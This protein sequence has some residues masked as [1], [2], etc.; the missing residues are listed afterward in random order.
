M[1][2]FEVNKVLGAVL[3]TLLVVDVLHLTADAVFAPVNPK[4]PG[5]VIAAPG[6]PATGPE[7]AASAPEEP[8]AQLLASASVERGHEATRVCEA[9]H[10][11]NKGG[12]NRVGPNLWGVV[13]RPRASEPGFNYS[14]AMKSEGGEWTFEELNKFLTNPRRDIPGTAMTFAGIDRARQRA[15]VIA[16][17]RTLSDN[18]V[19]LPSTK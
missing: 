14:T 10:T 16:Y 3:G 18:P 12:S 13:D 7:P 17:L 1:D 15:D 11:F 5:Y 8:I 9:C 19:P 6:S 4:E 2:S